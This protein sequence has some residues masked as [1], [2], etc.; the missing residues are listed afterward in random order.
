MGQLNVWPWVRPFLI[1]VLVVTVPPVVYWFGYVQSSVQ[2]AKQQGYTTLSAVTADFRTR[3]LA[4]DQI[5]VK[6]GAYARQNAALIREYLNSVVKPK[7]IATVSDEMHPLHLEV[8]SDTGGLLL[9][10]AGNACTAPCV[11][12]AAIPLE[13]LIPWNVV[14]TEFDGL[15]VLSD[16]NQLLA[17]DRRL[18]AQP[19]GVPIPLRVG[20]AW[21]DFE[22]IFKG[23]P[24]DTAAGKDGAKAKADAATSRSLFDFRDDASVQL[25]GVDYVAFL[26]VVSVPVTPIAAANAAADASGGAPAQTKGSSP[27]IKVLVVGL[28]AK[29]RLRREAIQLSPQ[30]LILVGALVAFGLFAIPFLKL[31]FIGERERMRPRDI[32]LLGG[33]ILA[34]T[35][36]MV[37]VTLDVHARSKLSDRFDDGLQR[38]TDEMLRHLNLETTAALAELRASAPLLLGDVEPLSDLIP[39]D[40]KNTSTAATSPVGS[41]LSQRDFASYPDH[42]ALSLLDVCGNQIRKWMPRTIATPNI[43]NGQQPYFAPALTLTHASQSYEADGFAFGVTLAPTTGLLLGIYATPVDSRTKQFGPEIETALR[44]GVVAVATPMHSVS[45][46]V[47]ARPFQF[48]LVDRRG[49]VQF[50]RTLGS[51]SG[52]RFF[53]AVHG[54][55]FLQQAAR[56]DERRAQTYQYRGKAYR[57]TA[58]D[59]PSLQLTLVTYYDNA[60]I[61]RLPAHAFATAS[62]FA[63][64]IIV[65]MFLGATIS[66]LVFR[67]DAFDWAWPS[68]A[69]TEHYILGAVACAVAMLI[70]LLARSVLRPPEFAWLVLGAPVVVIVAL[71]TGYMT[72]W[73]PHLLRDIHRTHE[74]NAPRSLRLMSFMFTAFG[75]MALL[76]FVAWPT[77]IAFNDAF[78]VHSAALET[79]VSDSWRTARTQWDDE[80]GASL[81]DVGKPLGELNCK[82]KPD[83]RCSAP[84]RIYATERNYTRLLAMREELALYKECAS[85]RNPDARCSADTRPQAPS[86]FTVNTASWLARFSRASDEHARTLSVFAASQA[87]AVRAPLLQGFQWS[88]WGVGGLIL[89]LAALWM[90]VRSIATHVLGLEVTDGGLLDESKDLEQ[91]DG[92]AWLL[93]RPSQAVLEAMREPLD[94]VDLRNA[95]LKDGI[96]RPVNGRTLLVQHVETRL[97]EAGWRAAL[98]ALLDGHYAGCVILTSDL[99]PLHYL[100]QQVREKC[101]S[102]RTLPAE[103]KDKR[104]EAEKTCS[105]L[106]IELADWA[107]ALRTVRKLRET[108]P[109][110]PAFAPGGRYAQLYPKLAGECG[111]TE[112]LIAIGQRLLKRTD[113]DAYRWNDIVGFVLD[114]AEPY[115]RSIWELCSREERLVLIQ[116]AQVGLVNP[117]REDIVRRLARRRLVVV[118]PRFRLMSQSF[119]RFVCAA[120]PQERITEWERS[121]SAMSWSRLGTPLYAL[122]AMVIAVLLFAE[123]AFFTNI[124]AV[125]TGSAVTLGSLRSIYTSVSKAAGAS[126]PA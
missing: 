126:K 41:S 64:G 100:T 101:D 4:H 70:L 29:D 91:R 28:I 102:I 40:A 76:A 26:Q 48:V 79:E 31:R 124:L 109:A 122:A 32:W 25:A 3:L 10:V 99:D 81:V 105:E 18:P 92:T 103:E 45:S 42:E 108:T 89:L 112:P 8:G 117:K 5:A 1:L 121:G 12:Q 118:D 88:I 77:T 71:G 66:V 20:D 84:E 11:V 98:L 75:V 63:L 86:S 97:G 68:T 46:T 60:E 69:R 19:L 61:G 59:L 44:T 53:E 9:N 33:S 119:M 47:I 82:G 120:E 96:T 56:S 80:N 74:G 37:L 87:S 51:F 67:D 7:S 15:L 34:T 85:L 36:L 94:K 43:N 35:A 27:S 104:A 2:A 52:E 23:Q 54:G 55:A 93:L 17:Q 14:E 113:L 111:S 78:N 125:A 30:T 106:R 90:L 72:S 116:L 115:Y 95:Q 39:C 50:Q 21:A 38:F 62:M 83:L 57:M 73:V 65:A 49:V 13:N 16:G 22:K 58:V 123:Q 24:L 107:E 114:A 110:F 6:A